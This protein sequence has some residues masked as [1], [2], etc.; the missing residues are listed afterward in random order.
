[1]KKFFEAI[2]NFFIGLLEK[3]IITEPEAEE[4]SSELVEISEVP[5]YGDKSEAVG[6]LQAALNRKGAEP[7]LTVDNDFGAKTKAALQAFQKAVGLTGTGVIPASGGETFEQLG[8]TLSSSPANPPAP[9]LYKADWPN[10]EWSKILLEMLELYGK[11]LLDGPTPKDAEAFSFKATTREERKA[12]YLMLI[13]SMARYE[14]SFKPETKYTEGFK[15]STGEFVISR[16]LI[17]LSYESV[18][19]YGVKLK[20]AEELHDVRKNLEATVVI[21]NRWVSRDGVIAKT[22]GDDHF[23]GAR[24]WS[25]LRS[26]KPAKAKIQVKL[27]EAF[28]DVPASSG[29]VKPI[30]PS[31]HPHHPRFDVP[32]PY[33]H[34]HPLDVLRSVAG[35]KEI[36]GVKDNP[37]IAHFHE[38][39][40][41]LGTHSDH[42]DYSDEVPGCSS[43]LNW[44]ADMSGC[45]KSNSALAASWTSNY[46][47]P[48][49]GDWVEEG[50][51]I[52]KKTGK[53]NHVTL[54][55]KRFNRRTAKYYEGFGVNQNDTIKTST[56]LVSDIISVQVWKPLPGTVLAPIGILGFKPVPATG[57]NDE[58]TR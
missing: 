4:S 38:H 34:L 2:L 58:S 29:G 42:N 55:N 26:S 22:T 54:C 11:D 31:V 27:K 43:G 53:Q 21:L 51:I 10:E 36:K 6:I 46:N 48:R 44:A 25:V 16:G 7:K 37:L 5:A 12:F 45:E 1:M 32:K 8:L 49:Q 28:K 57:G 24:Y 47:N 40:G 52:H 3:K 14:S 33:T 30:Y 9:L 19:A 20:N 50:D 18:R 35:E 56:Y 15:D 13:S 17:Q 41:N 39:S 23:G